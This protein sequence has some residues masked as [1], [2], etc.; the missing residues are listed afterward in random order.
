MEKDKKQ[1]KN[2]EK[3]KKKVLEEIK[4]SEKES[5]SSDVSPE[6]SDIPSK[7]P[8]KPDEKPATDPVIIKDIPED[9]E[10]ERR[11]KSRKERKTEKKAR[12]KARPFPLR[13]LIQ[14]L[15]TLFIRIPVLTILIT[16]L[17]L[18]TAKVIL[19][20]DRVQDL[21]ISSFNELSYGTIDLKVKE[22]SPYGGFVMEDI[23][24]RNGEEFNKTEFVKIKKIAVKYSFFSMLIGRMRIEEVGIYKPRIYLREKKGKWNAALLMKP[25]SK[26]EKPLKEE[27]EPDDDDDDGEPT[28][29]IKLPIHGEFFLKFIL[30]DLKVYA[31]GSK[32]DAFLD[33]LTYTMEVDVPPFKTIPKSI[34]AVSLL[35]KMNIVLNPKK[36]MDISF[37][38]KEAK[39]SAPLVCTWKLIFEKDGK[40]ATKF[41]SM[42]KFGTY[43]TP[44]RIKNK[45]L[46][47]L[48]FMISYDLFY[49]PYKDHLTLKHF[50]MSFKGK[51]WINLAGTVGEVTK[52]QKINI[53]M[54]ESSIN[55]KD[56]RPYMVTFTG[57]R[58]TK[59]GGFISLHPLTIKGSPKGTINVN[60]AFNIRN[61]IFNS[62]E[63]KAGANM[64]YFS[65][66][67]V[68]AKTGSNINA[69]GSMDI[70][71]LSFKSSAAKASGRI[72]LFRL[73]YSVAMSGSTMK[74]ATSIDIPHLFFTL[75]RSKSG[76]N[77]FRMDLNATTL[78][79]N[80]RV[81]INNFT[82]KYYNPVLRKNVLHMTMGGDVKLKPYLRGNI[83]I[84][85]LRILK[86]PVVGMVPAVFR[87]KIKKIPLKKPIDMNMA[88]AFNLGNNKQ[89]AIVTMGVAVPDYQITDLRMNVNALNDPVR[90]RANLYKFHLGSKIWNFNVNSSGMV[91]YTKPPFSDSDLK[92]TVSF[93]NPEKR[94]IKTPAGIA[95]LQGGIGLNTSMKGNLKNGKAKGA[96]IIDKLF[97][98]FT[99]NKGK[100]DEK[101]YE[102]NNMNL[103]FPFEYRF[104]KKSTGKSLLAVEKSQIIESDRFKPKDNFTITS[105]VAPHPARKVQF[106]YL[107]DF[108]GYIA[109]KDNIF[110]ME[111]F[112]AYV[113]DGSLYI[114]NVLFNLADFKP[115]NMEYKL[116]IDVTNVDIGKLDEPD[117][118][119]KTRDAELSLNANFSGRGVNIKKE[120]NTK[121]YINVHKIGDEFANRL[122]KGLSTEKGES[123]LGGLTQWIVDNS[124]SVKGFNFNLDKGLV[125][126]T[127]T[128]SRGVLGVV[129]SVEKN[130]VQ[131]DRLPIQ[132]YLRKVT[133][134][135]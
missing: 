116:G 13:I 111:N 79:N 97:V 130:K 2:I 57:F 76:D 74:V 15:K 67:Y 101:R 9:V 23:L 126:T 121:G 96:M 6:K 26:K 112:R 90:K 117:P 71:N 113:L 70:K 28:K 1:K 86:D 65:L 107:K 21:I 85:N 68:V 12:K 58:Y 105:V 53:K 98:N 27:D 50:G 99:R 16:I 75:N 106:S 61:F 73:P 127:V 17:S 108:A 124:M 87:E 119:K 52:N 14:I 62:P 5:V 92:L 54:T 129:A 3:S 33:G 40:E 24:I 91:N 4:K 109:F 63:V 114:K 66:S 55:L 11:K 8:G 132:E 123:K 133:K 128:L 42:F 18:V 120:L 48:N 29:E 103:N 10:N 110:R 78:N 32:F 44:V 100:E 31:Y 125:Y 93:K 115:E 38:S 45:H 47:P 36:T 7:K 72:P 84:H 60:G 34:E 82:M 51:K 88:V 134:G 95:V 46:T 80:S 102:L 19:T 89:K 118:K 25:G 35:K 122:M 69:N 94:T 135:E 131:F 30:D 77:G 37:H 83:K 49:N 39:A 43:K 64:P 56:L 22:F 41:N 81:V 20:P 59:L 104:D